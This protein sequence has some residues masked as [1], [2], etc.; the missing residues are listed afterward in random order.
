MTSPLLGS[1][2]GGVSIAE[3]HSALAEPIKA[4]LNGEGSL[5][6]DPSVR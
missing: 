6:N 2:K 1:P 3:I 4:D 5:N